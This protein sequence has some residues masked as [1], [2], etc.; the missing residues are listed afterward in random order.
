MLIDRDQLIAG[1][2]A[3]R[4]RE[5]VR[6]LREHPHSTLAFADHFDIDGHAAEVTLLALEA[7]GLVEKTGQS[8]TFLFMDSEA[9]GVAELEPWTTTIAGNALAKA[10]LGKPMPR[11]KAPACAAR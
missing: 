6:L 7:E 8:A 11:A 4:A 10:H 9:A 3:V 5:M 1:E 2:P